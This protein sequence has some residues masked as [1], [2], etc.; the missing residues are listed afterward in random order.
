MTTSAPVVQVTLLHVKDCPLVEAVRTTLHDA[1]ATTN[2][3]AVIEEVEGPYASPTLL[4]DGQDVTGAL[5][6]DAMSCRLDLPTE[7][8]VLTALK[9]ARP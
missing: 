9:G 7:A 5:S 4:V 2:I 3:E 8:Q 6:H 1:L